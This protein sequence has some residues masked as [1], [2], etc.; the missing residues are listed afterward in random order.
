MRKTAVHNIHVAVALAMNIIIGLAPNPGPA[1]KLNKGQKWQLREC[2]ISSRRVEQ[3]SGHII[4]AAMH[5]HAF[6]IISIRNPLTVSLHA[7]IYF[8]KNNSF[9][10]LSL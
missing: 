7:F 3:T 1:N 4:H 8:V 6:D 9:K 10:L 5:I 2:D